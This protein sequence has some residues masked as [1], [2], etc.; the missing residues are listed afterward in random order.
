MAGE[1]DGGQRNER[2]Q[3]VTTTSA[4]P[5]TRVTDAVYLEVLHFLNEEA[6]LLDD[7]RFDEWLELLTEDV[8]YRM[9]VTVTRERGDLPTHARDMEIMSE[10]IHSLR[11]RIDRLKTEFA[12][13]E[14]PPSR[15]RH[16]VTN[17]I[18]RRGSSDDEVLASSSF[19][20]YW[21]RS[22]EPQGDFFIGHRRDRLV[23]VDGG[24]RLAARDLFL[25]TATLSANGVTI[26]F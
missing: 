26:L 17:V 23:R 13:A 4:V 5:G 7:G 1:D 22:I 12:W 3:R 8:S 16:L 10:S 9:P 21:S 25:D 11:L 18:V 24:W 20:V 6:Q 15:T 2:G 14:D 19:C